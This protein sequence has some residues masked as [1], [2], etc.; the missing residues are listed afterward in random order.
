MKIACFQI[1]TWQ[2]PLLKEKLSSHNLL[3]FKE[4]LSQKNI[5]PAKEAEII[6]LRATSL[7]LKLTK[8]ILMQFPA[9]KFIATM[10]TGFDH[11]DMVT[12]KERKIQ[13]SN[14]LTYGEDTVAEY[15]LA[16]ILALSRKIIHS[17][18]RLASSE[19]DIE[20]FDLSGKTIGIIGSGKIGFKVINL[21]KAFGMRVIAYDIF[22]NQEAANSLNFQ[23]V[24]LEELLSNSDIIS[25]HAPLTKETYHI[26]NENNISKIKKS[27]ILINTARGGLI[28]TNALLK[29]LDRDIIMA[30]GLDVI[31]GEKENLPFNEQSIEVQKLIAHPRVLS[32]PHNAW[33]SKEAKQR[34]MHTTIENMLAFIQGSPKNL[35]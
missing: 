20:G 27:T 8:E 14:V 17:T 29:A 23:Y 26:I 35:I 1:E 7:D 6:M 19:K 22:Q 16:L 24:S 21:A 12:C 33:N 28:N 32:T 4:P 2:E 31:D 34:M 30:A 25:L 5:H 18:N 3:L 11:I 13:V 10:S 15:T 9:L